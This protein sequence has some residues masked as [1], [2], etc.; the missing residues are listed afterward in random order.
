MSKYL[1]VTHGYLQVMGYK[2]GVLTM[3]LDSPYVRGD[4]LLALCGHGMKNL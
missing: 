1:S 3:R 2:H 4:V